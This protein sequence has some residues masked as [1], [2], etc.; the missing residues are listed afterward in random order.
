[1]RSVQLYRSS[2]G[3]TPIHDFFQTLPSKAMQKVAW[4]LEL[5]EQLE[6]VPR[7]YFKKL[8]GTE[9]LW[10][11]RVEAGSLAIRLLSFFDEGNVVVVANGFLKKSEKVPRHEIERAEQRRRDYFQEKYVQHKK[12]SND[13][14]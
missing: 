6:Y 12:K 14:E 10:E 7:E 11:V 2:S 8:H 1:M 4:T 13:N 3:Q 9:E 5:V